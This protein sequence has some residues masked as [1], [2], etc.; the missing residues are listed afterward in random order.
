MRV[1]VDVPV[2]NIVVSSSNADTD[3]RF[4]RSW[5]EEGRICCCG[6]ED[7]RGSYAETIF[8]VEWENNCDPVRGDQ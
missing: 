8:F 1:I 3:G 4:G 6:R 7:E 5:R 2:T